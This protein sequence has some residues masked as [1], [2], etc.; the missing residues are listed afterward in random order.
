MSRLNIERL[1]N[2]PEFRA[3]S[4]KAKLWIET[5]VQSALDLGEPDPIFA[6]LSAYETTAGENART[7]SYKILGQKKIKNALRVWRN[8]SKR[9][10]ALEEIAAELEK[11]P[12][13]SAARRRLLAAKA[14]LLAKKGNTKMYKQWNRS[15]ALAPEAVGA[16]N[17]AIS[18]AV[19]KAIQYFN[20]TEVAKT[21]DDVQRKEAIRLIAA[22]V[23]TQIVGIAES[24]KA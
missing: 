22:G 14:K 10:V 8:K 19:E 20:E 1:K 6:T 5:Y 13:G 7:L 2:T 16:I 21:L 24:L 23:T 15:S 17:T 18:D 3:L 11:T 12:P 4:A 9:E